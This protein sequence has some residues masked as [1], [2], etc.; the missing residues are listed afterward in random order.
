M[1]LPPDLGPRPNRR[2][3][4]WGSGLETCIHPP[5]R[6][7]AHSAF[8][9]FPCSPKESESLQCR[10][11]LPF[12]L[13]T[14]DGDQAIMPWCVALVMICLHDVLQQ[15]PLVKW[16]ANL[17]MS[18]LSFSYLFGDV[19]GNSIQNEAVNVG[20]RNRHC[21]HCRNCPSGWTRYQSGAMCNPLHSLH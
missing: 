4:E 5:S 1:I 21:R 17:T 10:S 15:K 18:A 11:G 6:S 9:V 20:C 14:L 3:L 8:G 19:I 12:A 16:V 13:W 7:L 2:V